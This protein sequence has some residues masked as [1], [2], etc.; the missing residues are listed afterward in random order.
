MARFDLVFSGELIEGCAPARVRR[1][2]ER[3]F[4]TDAD[5]VAR[6]F[7]GRPVVIKRDLDEQTAA[8]YRA[9][10]QQ[11]GALCRIRPVA[12]ATAAAPG[13]AAQTPNAGTLAG[14]AILPPGS[15]LSEDRQVDPPG[16]DLSAFDIAPPGVTLVEPPAS[17]AVPPRAGV[18]DIAATGTDLADPRPVTPAPI[19]DISALTMAPPRT[20]VLTPE[21][22]AKPVPAPPEA[23]DLKLAD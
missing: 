19:P 16:F 23:P 8:R 10:L 14:V 3:L 1:D 13:H 12:D 4:R 15:L 2:L 21:E 17:T 7:T 11:V 9:A 5:S 6:L 22:R 20:E 18:Y